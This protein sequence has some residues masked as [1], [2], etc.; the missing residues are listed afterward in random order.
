MIKR[1]LLSL[2]II[3]GV[4]GS[5]FVGTKA[6]LSS[7]ATLAANSF[8]TGTA[9][10]QISKS[11]SSSPSSWTDDSIAGFTGKVLPGQTVSQ[12]VWLRNNSS[13]VDF[14]IAAQSASISGEIV[15][16][17]VT[18]AFTPVNNDGTSSVGT[19]VSH[20][21]TDWGSPTSLGTTIIHNNGKQRY[22][23]DVSFSS[24]IS[25][26]GSSTFDFIFTGTQ[27]P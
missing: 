22:K 25:T 27:T 19:P 2:F 4:S 7:Q 13:D 3:I 23:M 16:A 1:L 10:L 12:T 26:A 15:P 14:S 9:G 17:N 8:S 5:V 18:V 6:L 11:I 24:S 20:T 21:L